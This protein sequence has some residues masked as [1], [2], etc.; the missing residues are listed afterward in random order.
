MRTDGIRETSL[1]LVLMM[2][3]RHGTRFDPQMTLHDSELLPTPE[4][5]G[6]TLMVGPHTM[7]SHLFA[8]R[9]YDGGVNPT[10]ISVMPFRISGTRTDAKVLIPS[11]TMFVTIRSIFAAG[12]TIC[13]LIDRGE[14]ERRNQ[15]IVTSRGEFL[16]STPLLE[17]ALRQRARILFMTARIAEDG[18]VVATVIRP[19][20]DENTTIADLL[21]ELA[22]FIDQH[23]HP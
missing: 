18:H 23:V 20:Q 4:T 6:A 11:R 1:D 10:C 21:G 16:I 2:L 9:L 8:R 19:R 13:A 14:E 7:L 17:L 5:P 15:P 12:G 22:A 3:T